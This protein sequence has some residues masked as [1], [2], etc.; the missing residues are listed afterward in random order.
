MN[1]TIAIIGAGMAG[2]MAA[3]ALRERGAS[4]V[5]LEK[6]RGVGGRM[7]TKRVG[8]AVFD[9]GAQFFTV[10]DAAMES[11]LADWERSGVAAK[12]PGEVNE[13][14]TGRPGMTAV[15]KR[16]SDGLDIK[17]EHKVTA[18]MRVA[19]GWEL[20]I[21]GHG[22]MRVERLVST[23]PVPQ[24]LA[25]L[26][27]GGVALKETLA[28]ELGRV[29]Y[30]PC[31]ALLVVLDGASAVPVEGV[32]IKQGPLRWVADNAKKGISP[33]GQGA[34]TL[35][36]TPAFS[37][38]HYG[39]TE[40]EVAELLVPAAREWLGSAGV[41]SV[42]LH[43]WRYSEPVTTW[44][45]RCVWLPEISLGLAGDAFGGPRVEG[46]A[47]SGLA[48]AARIADTLEHEESAD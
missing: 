48:L 8:T 19:D 35:L 16:L 9:Q 43:R 32:A 36:A 3:R 29:S 21:E 2:L 20:M 23:A 11:W 24:T 6:S 1:K 14:W 10:R 17:R 31:L 27:A 22:L 40:S 37:A 7:A 42:A 12:W 28:A 5:V 26:V 38:E 13:R 45:E 41:V 44:A 33:E 34:V 47:L 39:K 4:V 46:A 30:H 18:A 25:L 15:A